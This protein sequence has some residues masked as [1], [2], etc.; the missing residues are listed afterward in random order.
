MS[1][2]ADQQRIKIVSPCNVLRCFN[3][4]SY[5]FFLNRMSGRGGRGGGRG[6]G[7]FGRG[8]QS[9]ASELIRDNL[10]DLGLDGYS[11]FDDRSPP[12]LYPPFEAPN[13]MIP[14]PE[15]IWAVHKMTDWQTKYV[16]Q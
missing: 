6:G 1:F 5:Y 13:P 7:R 10:E 14:T 9:V 11:M 12:P 4:P 15:D 16:T 2:P 3:L 8:G